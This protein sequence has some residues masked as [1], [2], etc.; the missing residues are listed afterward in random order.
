MK[1]K[2][3]KVDRVFLSIT[4]ILVIIGFF[5]FTSASLGLL[6]KEK[7]NFAD[8]AFNQTFF[9]LFLGTI[10]LIVF[11]KIH[12]RK[13]RKYALY[14]FLFS[15]LLTLMVFI[16][17][18][19]FEHGGARR[20]VSLGSISFQPAEFLK[21]GFIIYLATW[22]SGIKDGIKK[23]N[24][25]LI[26]FIFLTAIVATILFF[27]PDIGTLAVIGASGFA[28]F[29]TAGAR[30]RDIILTIIIAILGFSAL[31]FYKPYIKE[32]IM[33]F[34]EPNKDSQR[35]SYQLQQSLIAIGAGGISG[36]GFGQSIQKF[37]FLPEPVGDSIFAVAA[38]EFGFLGGVTLILLYLIFALR[39]FRIA[40]KSPDLFG[41]LL[42]VGIIMLIIS[43]SFF[44]IASMLG[45]VPLSGLPLLFVS[46]GGTALFFTLA[47]VGIILNVSRYQN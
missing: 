11:S 22:L 23:I 38:E 30:W 9:G 21:I 41:G 29:V 36:R 39:G 44:N 17:Q 46:H 33:T 43:Q 5:I 42:V 28:V 7:G 16:P 35:S 3:N 45:V 13:L 10:A 12:Y 37:G 26:P 27:Q 34:L 1:P 14:I 40:K 20:W 31:A 6:A 19:G 15:A 18:F 2:S 32:R 4:A 24:L 47:S 8:V 25:G